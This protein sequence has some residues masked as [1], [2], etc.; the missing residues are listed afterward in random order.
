MN[1]PDLPTRLLTLFP[2]FQHMPPATVDDVI[3]HC[4]LRTAPVGTVLFT[5]GTLCESFPLVL[6]GVVRVSKVGAKGRE[7]PLYRVRP[8]ESCVITTS[9]LLGDVKY[10]A[11]GVVE[12]DLAALAMS[13]DFFNRL[14]AEQPVFREFVFHLFTERMT[15]LM[16]VVE[17]VAF[18]RLDERLAAL[19]LRLGS[20]V[21]ATH[22]HLADELGSVREMVSRLLRGFEEQGWIALRREHIEILDADALKKLGSHQFH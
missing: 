6:A 11:T 13:G 21:R 9:C 18:R 22:Q 3:R 8:G 2:F 14:I 1:T 20:P 4:P 5:P 19:L 10:S 16:Q 7:L 17:E 15:D 12:E